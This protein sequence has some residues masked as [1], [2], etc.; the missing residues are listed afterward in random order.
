MANNMDGVLL[1]LCL[2]NFFS[3]VVPVPLQISD[4]NDFDVHT[5]PIEYDKVHFF[6]S[7]TQDH[8]LRPGCN[9]FGDGNMDM[10]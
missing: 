3:V 2:T 5:A 6:K 10:Y 4:K 9:F 7:G 8:L 1:V